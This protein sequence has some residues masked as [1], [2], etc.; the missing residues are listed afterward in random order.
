M[1]SAR[2]GDPNTEANI[3]IPIARIVVVTMRRTA[4]PGIVVPVSATQQ[5][6]SSIPCLYYKLI[7]QLKQA[8]CRV[9][10]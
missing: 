10:K 9:G 8:C 3:V 2:Q 7:R 4:I 6:K 5:L 1:K